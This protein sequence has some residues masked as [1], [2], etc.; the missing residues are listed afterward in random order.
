MEMTAFFIAD[1]VTREDLVHRDVNFMIPLQLEFSRNINFVGRDDILQR[2]HESI[3]S[4]RLKGPDR[5]TFSIFEMD[6]IGKTQIIHE[7]AYRYRKEFSSIS[8]VKANSYDSAVASYFTIAQTLVDYAGPSVQKTG[9]VDMLDKTNRDSLSE[10][11]AKRDVQV[12]KWWLNLEGNNKWLLLFDSR[13]NPQ[14][15]KKQSR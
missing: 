10:A 12:I 11:F 15:K 2:I 14:D 6:G 5:I 1:K 3:T 13:D 4:Q 8:W 7:Y 9:L